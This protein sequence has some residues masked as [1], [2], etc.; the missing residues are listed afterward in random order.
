MKRAASSG[1]GGYYGSMTVY[2]IRARA[3]GWVKI[4]VS[5]T[6]TERLRALQTGSADRLRL[7]AEGPGGHAQEA[8]IHAHYRKF[9]RH[10]EWFAMPALV[11]AEAIEFVQSGVCPPSKRAQAVVGRSVRVERV[12]EQLRYSGV[13]PRDGRPRASRVK[14][15]RVEPDEG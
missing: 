5:A 6:P 9:R 2:M 8:A 14:V 11:R 10:G 1:K 15:I 13:I 7:I 4:G 3:S 12:K